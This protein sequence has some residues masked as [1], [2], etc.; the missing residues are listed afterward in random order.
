M[1]SFTT[2]SFSLTIFLTLSAGLT[3]AANSQPPASFQ[4]KYCEGRGDIEYLRMIDQSFGFFTPNPDTQNISMLYNKD[5][6]S[7]TEGEAWGGAWWVQNSYGPSFCMMPFLRDPYRTFLANSQDFW[8]KWQGNGKNPG[9]QTDGPPAPDG[10][11]CDMAVRDGVTYRQGDAKWKIHDWFFEATAAGTLLQAEMILVNHDPEMARRYI[12]NLDRAC[13]FIETRRDPRNG[14]FLVGPACNLLAP[15]YGGIRQPDGTFG[16]AYL[17]GLSVTYFATLEHMIEIFRLIG[18]KEKENLYRARWNKT[19]DSLPR[20]LDPDGNYFV[21]SLEQGGIRHGVFGQK[22]F[23]Y[24][25]A[26]P[27][28][29][30]ICHRVVNQ[31]LAERIYRQIAALPQLRPHDL[32]ITNYPGLDDTYD[33]W[34]TTKTNGLWEYGYWVNGGVWETMEARAIMAYYRLGRYEDIRRSFR[35]HMTFANKFQLDAPLTKFGSAPWFTDKLINLCYDA[36]G[37]PAA[38]VRGLFEYRYQADRLILYPHIPPSIT[39]YSQKEPIRFGEKRIT[40][41]VI[42]G[43]PHIQ[44]A[45]VNGDILK[46]EAPDHVALPIDLLPSKANVELVMKGEWPKKIK[47]APAPETEASP[48]ARIAEDTPLP[49]DLAKP[50]ARLTSLRKKITKETGCDY[51]YDFLTETIAAFEAYRQRAAQDKAGKYPSLTPKKRE[52]ILAQY[53]RAALNLYTGFDNLMKRDA[54]EQNLQKKNFADHYAQKQ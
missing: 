2:R 46:I 5:F 35:Q 11:L 12:G 30:A 3:F 45:K 32:L 8:F 23:G 29:D 41:H 14:L 20:L 40:I 17:A 25:E 21:K 53:H 48:L 51:E 34:G 10:S 47:P 36:M 44:S 6:D 24:F 4:G 16:R 43:G 54:K 31:N 13:N 38:V 26:A 1:K 28:V 22:Q 42:N 50:F 39:E 27:N 49:P 52:A 19:K 37:V 18:D 7:L 9:M 33:F 15:S